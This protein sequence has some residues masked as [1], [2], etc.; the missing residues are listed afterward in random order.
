M[1][2]R[3]IASQPS[4][5]SGAAMARG[6][7]EAF[8]ALRVGEQ[9]AQRGGQGGRVAGRD[10]LGGARGR[11]LAEAADRA[12]QQ[13]LAER[14]RREQHAGL[15]DLAVGQDDEIGAPEDGR[16]LRAADEARQPAHVRRSRRAQGREVHPRHAHEPQLGP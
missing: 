13:R 8:A 6:G 9:L 12:Q 4:G 14:Q 11:D 7:G 16:Q 3:A 15:V 2:R 10:E 1:V 5:P